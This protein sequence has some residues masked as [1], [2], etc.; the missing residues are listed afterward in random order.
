MSGIRNQ[1]LD[2]ALGPSCRAAYDLSKETS[3]AD[4]DPISTLTDQSG[5]GLTLTGVTT[6][7]PLFQANEINGYG[8]AQFDGTD[9]VLNAATAADWKFLHDGHGI[10]LICL[11]KQRDLNPDRYDSLIDTC[12]SSSANHGLHWGLDDRS[13]VPRNNRINAIMAKGS[14]G[15][16]IFTPVSAENVINPKTWHTHVLRYQCESNLVDRFPEAG[17]DAVLYADGLE[18]TGANAANLPH[19]TSNP[20][21]A[22]KVGAVGALF[23]KIDLAGLWIFDTAIPNDLLHSYFL[24]IRNRFD[25]SPNRIV[26]PGH[27]FAGFPGLT[28]RSDGTLV[29]VYYESHKHDPSGGVSGRIMQRRSGN[30]GWDWGLPSEVYAHATK[31]TRGTT[32]FTTSAGTL[33]CAGFT[34]DGGTDI[35]VFVVRS[36]DGGVSWSSPITPAHGFTL[37]SGAE[38]SFVQLSNGHLLMTCYGRLTAGT[39]SITKTVL[40]TDDGATWGSPV[41]I[42]DG[43]GSSKQWNEASIVKISG[44]Y[45]TETLLAIIRNDTDNRLD[46]ASSTDSGATWGAVSSALTG[47]GGRPVLIKTAAGNLILLCRHRTAPLHGVV[48]WSAD[49][50]T[51]WS[52]TD[53]K[54]DGV[55][56]FSSYSHGF[57]ISAARIAI[58]HASEPTTQS[59]NPVMALPRFR[60]HLEADIIG[61]T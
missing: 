42:A 29:A 13:S 47:L 23:A 56:G 46:K 12:A 27:G 32:I 28:R 6:A 7:R 26:S 49:N 37:W 43:P 1:A 36:T 39:F 18:I 45:P 11:V 44:T 40:S 8:V 38:A 48:R 9:D 50:G 5:N 3:Y 52:A 34:D 59:S 14:A 25:V 51:T 57:E 19:S 55:L 30:R 24:W 10:T 2:P 61:Y 16:P 54:I 15:N 4:T 31:D 41:T 53:Y 33:L 22:L 58:I 17:V 60:I 20:T 35:D 21:N